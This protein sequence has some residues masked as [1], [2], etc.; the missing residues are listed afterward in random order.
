MTASRLVRRKGH[1]LLLE[2]WPRVLAHVPDAQLVVIGRG[3]E[4][5]RLE[6]TTATLP[7]R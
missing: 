3:P 2:A 4:R 7:A 5:T 6:R 1:A